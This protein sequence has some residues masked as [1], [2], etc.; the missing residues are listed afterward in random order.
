MNF[1]IWLDEH[2]CL[3][4]EHGVNHINLFLTNDDLE[5]LHLLLEDKPW[6]NR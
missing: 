5:H 2:N 3:A 4:F 6:L 1:K